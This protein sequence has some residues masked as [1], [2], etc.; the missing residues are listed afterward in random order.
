MAASGVPRHS[1]DGGR[2]PPLQVGKARLEA[3]LVQPRAAGR[4]AEGE[5]GEEESKPSSPSGPRAGVGEEGDGGG[6]TAANLVRS[7]S[8]PGVAPPPPSPPC[9]KP[10]LLRCAS[11][12]LAEQQGKEE[13]G[14]GITSLHLPAIASLPGFIFTPHLAPCNMEKIYTYEYIIHAWVKLIPGLLWLL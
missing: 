13:G 2:L 6:V 14:G 12:R 1:G 11:D 3:G 10:P 4:A 8:C 5:A 9:S 7:T